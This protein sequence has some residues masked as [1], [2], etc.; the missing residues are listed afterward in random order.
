MTTFLDWFP[1][2]IRY[3]LAAFI[4]GF[5]ALVIYAVAHDVKAAWDAWKETR[6]G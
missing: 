1:T 2:I 4:F 6:R 3:I 5:A